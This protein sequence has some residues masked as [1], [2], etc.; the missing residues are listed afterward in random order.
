VYKIVV[1]ASLLATA[2]VPASAANYSK[3]AFNFGGGVSNP[4]NPTAQYAGTSGS[5]AGGVGYDFDN[6]NSVIGEFMWA[7]MP[8]SISTPH[9]ADGPLGRVN[10]YTFTANYRYKVDKLR[11]SHFGVYAIGG[12][13]WYYR[14]TSL[15][16]SYIVPP[17]T[18]CQPIFT[19]WG[20]ACD[21]NGFVDTSATF[22]KFHSAGGLNAG[23]GLTIRLGDSDWKFYT[24][25]RYHYAFGRIPTTLVLVTFGLRFN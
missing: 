1:V 24:E 25:S 10:L 2:A 4:L 23:A 7:G 15:N 14:Y 3:F 22:Y 6:H 19:W 20:F 11:G 17:N 5:V 18:V 8:S 16:R 21:P 9:P 12:G 13:G